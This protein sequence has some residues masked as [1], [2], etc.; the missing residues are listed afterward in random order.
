MCGAFS[1]VA[2]I[3]KIR[4]KLKK[5]VERAQESRSAYAVGAASGNSKRVSSKALR[6]R[7]EKE[8]GKKW[9]KD[10]KTGGNQDVSHKKAL[11]DKGTNNVDNIEPLQHGEHMRRHREAGDFRRW[12]ARRG[13]GK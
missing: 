7:W 3:K 8:T 4:E 11:A 6:R 12:G 2:K 13:D 5:L 1:A 9:P 10:P